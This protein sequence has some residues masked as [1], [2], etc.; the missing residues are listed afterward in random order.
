MQA[1]RAAGRHSAEK[2]ETQF[3]AYEKDPCK[4]HAPILP[5]LR[6]WVFTA[7]Q[8]SHPLL[9][10]LYGSHPSRPPPIHSVQRPHYAFEVILP[11]RRSTH[12]PPPSSRAR[13]SHGRLFPPPSSPLARFISSLSLEACKKAN[14]D[15]GCSFRFRGWGKEVSNWVHGVSQCAAYRETGISET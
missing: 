11:S 9:S 10:K 2:R 4:T 5:R 3:K 13:C 14:G 12:P 1:G 15:Q 7:M 6:R 8:R